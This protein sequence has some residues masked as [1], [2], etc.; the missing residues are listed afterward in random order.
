MFGGKYIETKTI[1]FDSNE[2]AQNFI[3]ELTVGISLTTKY[4]QLIVLC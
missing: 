4:P 2:K 3:K 1:F